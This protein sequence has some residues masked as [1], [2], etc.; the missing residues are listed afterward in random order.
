M[1]WM[2]QLEPAAKE[3]A[4]RPIREHVALQQALQTL[5]LLNLSAKIDGVYG[6]DTRAAIF[7]WQLDEHRPLTGLLDDVAAEALLP[8]PEAIGD[9]AVATKIISCFKSGY[10]TVQSMYACSGKWVTPRALLF[11]SFG[12]RCPIIA[13]TT[14]GR[15]AIIKA[16]GSNGLQTELTLDPLTHS[17]DGAANLPP[18][19]NLTQIMYCQT[20]STSKEFKDCVLAA[21]VSGP[22]NS[23]LGCSRGDNPQGTAS[24]L[25]HQTNNTQMA[26]IIDCMSGKAGTAENV[27]KCTN[28]PGLVE[29]IQTAS[30]CVN[31]GGTLNIKCILPTASALESNVGSCLVEAAGN[32]AAAAKC[33]ERLNPSAAEALNAIKCATDASTESKATECLASH[34]GGDAPNVAACIAAH[35]D[36]AIT[37]LPATRPEY[38]AAQQAYSCIENGRDAGAFIENCASNFIKDDKTREAMSCVAR[39]GSDKDQLAACAA[40]S[41]LPPDIARFAGCAASSQGPTSFALCAAAPLINEEWRIAAECAVQSGGNPIGFG[42]C[43]AGRLTARELTK[44]F[45]TKDCFGPNNTIVKYFNN[46]F[47][48]LL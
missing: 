14:D 47:H 38:K 8:S 41:V 12:A 29:Q 25:A 21:T 4:S 24:C 43:T 23:L 31:T 18:L 34:L 2:S 35:K 1:A 19:P 42:G 11:C 45:T 28:N 32:G 15:N 16:L 7:K 44:C 40:Q 30:N 22:S 9:I 17:P 27:V 10:Q 48:D 37:C 26:S 46:E 6:P 20:A 13:D 36:N 3:E 5:G 39:A 33:L